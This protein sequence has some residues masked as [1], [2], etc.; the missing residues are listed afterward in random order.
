MIVLGIVAAE[1]VLNTGHL[2]ISLD[3][4]QL[5][6]VLGSQQLR[7]VLDILQLRIV[8][9]TLQQRIEPDSLQQR[10]V[11]NIP[12]CC[13][14]SMY[15]SANESVL[16]SILYGSVLNRTICNCG[17]HWAFCSRVVPDKQQQRPLLDV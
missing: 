12:F 7:T 8:E 5:R 9:N 10:I 2:R 1:V 3:T 14:G 11:L 17:L 4:L 6:V 16:Y 13:W 15:N